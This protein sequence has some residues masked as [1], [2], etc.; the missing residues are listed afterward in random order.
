MARVIRAPRGVVSAAP[1]ESSVPPETKDLMEGTCWPNGCPGGRELRSG[2][3]PSFPT[4]ARYRALIAAAAVV[5]GGEEELDGLET[6]AS[7]WK[8]GTS[9]SRGARLCRLYNRL[10]RHHQRAVIAAKTTATLASAI[11]TMPQ[12]G[13]SVL[14][15][16]SLSTVLS[17]V[18]TAEARVG[19]LVIVLVMLV[20]VM[21]VLVVV[22]VLELVLAAARL[23]HE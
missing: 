22:V 4:E 3:E 20:L 8:S 16:L 23:L 9:C 7:S 1:I 10:H 17:T 11:T 2:S 5:E 18:G 15:G 13:I 6:S 19:G 14:D 21:V 12:I